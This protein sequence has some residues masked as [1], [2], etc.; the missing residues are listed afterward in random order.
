MTFIH[1]VRCPREMP[2]VQDVDWV[3]SDRPVLATADGCIRVT[4]IL[5][6]IGSSPIHDYQP[7]G[8]KNV[9]FKIRITTLLK[10]T[11]NLCNIT[12]GTIVLNDSTPLFQKSHN[13]YF[14][15]F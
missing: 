10:N 14:V 3:G 11:S 15:I 8:K 6:K 9:Y 4:D 1:Q 7:S 5:L 2:K 12:N 13:S